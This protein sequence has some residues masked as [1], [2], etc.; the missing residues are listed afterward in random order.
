[1]A[2]ET[3]REERIELRLN[4]LLASVADL[5]D[6]AEEWCA[7]GDA[8]RTS[9]SL[10][11]DHLMADYLTELDIDYEDG[12]MAGGQQTRYRQLLRKLK[13]IMPIIQRLDWYRPTIALDRPALAARE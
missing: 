10:D 9:L 6:I 4:A 13:E 2:T 8:E 5:P 12:K 1:M 3:T 7:L 11:W